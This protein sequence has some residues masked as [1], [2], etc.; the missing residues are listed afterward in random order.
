MQLYKNFTPDV[1]IILPTFNREKYLPR[2]IESVINQ[3]FKNWELIIV[4]DGS[5]DKSSE[6]ISNYLERNERIRFIQKQKTG[7]TISR[8]LGIKLASGNYLTFL[9]SDDEYTNDHLENRVRELESDNSIDCLHG[10]VEIIGDPY[11][12]DKNYPDKKIH[13]ND[14]IVCATF[15]GKRKVFLEIGGF[16]DIPYSAESDFY[17]RA[18]HSFTFKRVSTPSYIYHRDT[19]DSI[20]NNI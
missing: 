12:K 20:C 11:V 13:I 17:E 3:T 18:M 10:G 9:D 15:F 1:S 8:N 16:N 2:S 19:P 5:T 7:V 6:L 4:D 14:C